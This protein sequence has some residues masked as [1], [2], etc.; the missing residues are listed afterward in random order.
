MDDIYFWIG[1]ATVPVGIVMF[2]VC[3]V[4]VAKMKRKAEKSISI[5]L[6]DVAKLSA[7]ILAMVIF[8]AFSGT[9]RPKNELTT[10]SVEYEPIDTI[11]EF[12][13]DSP[14]YESW[15]SKKSKLGD[16]AK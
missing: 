11:T 12:K 14:R 3:G 16:L 9:Y 15:E 6:S 8:M 5:T 4:S 10:H 1:K 2:L 13:A 7:C